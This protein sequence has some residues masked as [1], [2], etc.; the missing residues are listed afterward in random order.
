MILGIG[1]IYI[2]YNIP[3]RRTESFQVLHAAR[4]VDASHAIF[5][6]VAGDQYN[7]TNNMHPGMRYLLY[8]SASLILALDL[9]RRDIGDW[10]SPLN[11]KL[12]QIE[13][14]QTRE[15]GTGE[16]LFRCKEFQNWRDKLSETLWCVGMRETSS[17]TIALSF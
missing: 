8:L 1:G 11:F 17:L 12:T 15:A 7:I 9:E 2:Y 6:D 4:Q 3:T 16:W 10:L 5:S 13:F 14:F